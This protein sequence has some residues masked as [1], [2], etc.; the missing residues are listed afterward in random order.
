MTDF[1]SWIKQVNN[2]IVKAE[3]LDSIGE[4]TTETIPSDK[5]GYNWLVYYVNG[6]EVRKVYVDNPIDKGTESNPYY[7]AEGI[8]L[9]PNAFYY[10][11][12]HL[13]VYMGNESVIAESWD[14]VAERMA[15]W[16]IEA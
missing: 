5:L 3:M 15:Q 1:I 2:A 13:Y 4:V 8:E 14:A 9:R 10:Y 12:E 11:N 6:I 16:D 7:F